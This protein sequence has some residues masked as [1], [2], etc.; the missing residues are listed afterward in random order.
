MVPGQQDATHWWGEINLKENMTAL[1]ELGPLHLAVQRLP[2]EWRLIYEHVELP[3]GEDD[4]W[5]HRIASGTDLFEYRETERYVFQGTDDTLRIMPALADRSVVTRPIVPFTV[6]AGEEAAI[7]VSTPLWVHVQV[8]RQPRTLQFIPIQR[9]SDTWFGASTLEGEL[10]YASRTYGRLNLSEIP[11]LPHRAVTRVLIQNHADSV[12]LVERLN[13][14]V[15]YLSLF[16]A[17]GGRLWTEAVTMIRA[18][19]SS[20]ADLQIQKSP[21]AEAAEALLVASPRKEGGGILSIRAFGAIFRDA[22]RWS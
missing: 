21:P 2:K 6:L 17:Q 20:Q 9:P 3:S 13:L 19:D 10:C 16:V 11:L 12:L 5:T 14:P 7:F 4:R 22:T 1:W 15:P 8:G 18:R